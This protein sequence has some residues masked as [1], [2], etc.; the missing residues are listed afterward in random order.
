MQAINGP[1]KIVELA[2][3]K[4]SETDIVRYEDDY[5]RKGTTKL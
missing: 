4:F 5:K 2:W 3:G 1:A